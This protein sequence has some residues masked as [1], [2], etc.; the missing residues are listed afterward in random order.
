MNIYQAFLSR[1]NQATRQGHIT[2]TKTPDGEFIGSGRISLVVRQIVP[3]VVGPTET[4]G[5]QAFEV[6]AGNVMFTAWNGSECCDIIRSMLAEALPDWAEQ[7]DL[8]A[9]RLKATMAL[10]D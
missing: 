2:W 7:R 3:L 4:I 8:I 1:A 6:L 10:L 5:P 9:E